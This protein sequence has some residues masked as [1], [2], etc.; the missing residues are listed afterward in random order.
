[1]LEGDYSG[2]GSSF[3]RAP[4]KWLEHFALNMFLF[5][6]TMCSSI[7]TNYMELISVGVNDGKNYGFFS[8]L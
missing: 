7:K 5:Y 2:R 8:E 6:R 1:M 3:L 4:Q